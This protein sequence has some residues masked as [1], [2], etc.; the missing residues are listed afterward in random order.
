MRTIDCRVHSAGEGNSTLVR[1][2]HVGF[3]I[4][5][6]A[7]IV[8]TGSTG[9]CRTQ[10]VAKNGAGPY[11][12]A[13]VAEWRERTDFGVACEDY[14]GD[15]ARIRPMPARLLDDGHRLL[16][17]LDSV[18]APPAKIREIAPSRADE[19]SSRAHSGYAFAYR[20]MLSLFRARTAYGRASQ[21]SRLLQGLHGAWEHEHERKAH[22]SR[23]PGVRV[24]PCPRSRRWRLAIA[25]CFGCSVE[26]AHTPTSRKRGRPG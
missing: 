13:E 21:G 22:E 6:R 19:R 1:L 10:A 15:V 24:Q 18:A 25:T 20:F 14:T 17:T 12:L 26:T 7:L 2:R 23:A 4:R 8:C 9:V 3:P 11:C 5:R 16:R